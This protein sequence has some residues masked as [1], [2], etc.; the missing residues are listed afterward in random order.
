MKEESKRPAAKDLSAQNIYTWNLKQ[1]KIR[2]RSSKQAT[3]NNEVLSRNQSKSRGHTSKI[4]A[5]VAVKPA[6]NTNIVNNFFH[7]FERAR[8]EM[9]SQL[10]AYQEQ[11]EDES[12]VVVFW[13]KK[14]ELQTRTPMN[15]LTNAKMA[16]ANQLNVETKDQRRSEMASVTQTTFTVTPNHQVPI[17]AHPVRADST[18]A[19]QPPTSKSQLKHTLG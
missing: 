15:V 8:D 11:L 17:W 14:S 16:A 18:N 12:P 1:K 13:Q 5:V 9:K 3:Q 10:S 19:K 7:D 4:K 6:A 2:D